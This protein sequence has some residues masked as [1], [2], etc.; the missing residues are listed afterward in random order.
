MNPIFYCCA[1]IVMV[2]VF[3]A[4]AFSIDFVQL[5]IDEEER[6]E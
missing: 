5:D 4:R 3:A 1:G 2:L 6:N